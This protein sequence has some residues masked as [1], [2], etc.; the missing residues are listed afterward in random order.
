MTNASREEIEAALGR[1]GI[2]LGP[3]DAEGVRALF[4]RYAERLEL[5]HSADVDEEELAGQFIPQWA[6]GPER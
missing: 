4:E 2:R 1:L 6:D 5:L 3:E